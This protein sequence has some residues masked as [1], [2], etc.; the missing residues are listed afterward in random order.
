[1]FFNKKKST[2][3]RTVENFAQLMVGDLVT[4][5]FRQ[6]LPE[7]L[8]GESLRVQSVNTYDYAG[9]LVSDFMLSHSSGLRV[10]A[11]YDPS[12]DLITF[13]HKLKHPEIIEIFDGDQLA[14]IFDAQVPLASLDL[15][16]DAVSAE[17]AAWV[18]DRYTRR[19]C[20]AQGYYY[21]ED[22]REQG[23]SDYEDDGSVAF[24]Y[25]ELD[26][27]TEHHSMSIEI[28]EDGETEFFVEVSVSSSAVDAYF[29][30]G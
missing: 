22:R 15:R 2:P 23:L 16:A 13:S 28:W 7:G 18:C 4:L 12:Q 3:T 5:K 20:D 26:G 19:L 11:T 17:R 21:E 29:P 9:T 8:S 30:K 1:M 24:N 10:N 6:A 27:D 14:L 25:H